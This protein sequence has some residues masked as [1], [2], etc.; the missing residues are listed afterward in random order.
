[1][2]ILFN[3][4]CLFAGFAYQLNGK[5]KMSKLQKF[6]SAQDLASRYGVS[7][8]TVWYWLRI[9]KLNKP[10]KLGPNSTRWT[11]ETIEQFE[12][13]RSSESA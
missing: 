8:Q 9:G 11:I 7:K 4:S 1:M 12:A 6:F 13:D 10:I 3:S 2:P 5:T